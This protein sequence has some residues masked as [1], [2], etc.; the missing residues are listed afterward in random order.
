M[1]KEI[2]KQRLILTNDEISNLV[3]KVRSL[4]GKYSER[5]QLN[6]ALTLEEVL[7]DYQLAFGKDKAV[8]CVWKDDFFRGSRITISSPGQECNPLLM[9]NEED[10]EVIEYAQRMMN[11]LGMGTQYQYLRGCNVTTVKL[12]PKRKLTMLHQL[13]IAAAM[14]VLTMV[15][16]HFVP[17]N[18]AK[19][20]T[21]DFVTRIFQKMVSILA[22]LAT[23]LIFFALLTGIKNI[24]DVTSLGRMGKIVCAHLSKPYL[25]ALLLAP[26]ACIACY[27]LSLGGGSGESVFGSLLQLVLDII[28]DNLVTPLQVNNDLQV[29][30]IAVF[31]GTVLLMLKGEVS[32]LEKLVDES[33]KVVNRM[34]SLAC[35]GLPLLI[36]F[37]IISVS[38]QMDS[39]RIWDL[40]RF[41]LAMLAVQVIV[42]GF[43]VLRTCRLVRRPLKE[44][45]KPTVPALLI[46]L[47]TSSQM[48]SYPASEKCCK[49]GWGVEPKLFDFA[50][51]MGVVLYMPNGVVLLAITTWMMLY[52][53]GIPADFPMLVKVSFLSVIV[54][55][56]AP[57][58]PGS[59]LVVL[60]I[61]MTSTGVPLEFMPLGA[62]FVTVMGHIMPAMNG[63]CLQLEMLALG[64][65]LGMLK[66][67]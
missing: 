51:P 47:A 26:L 13:W 5:E 59:G 15:L 9:A 10:A 60:P 37:G 21:D 65:K 55:I 49:E 6:L 58:I 4:A 35:K 25:V 27:P 2:L 67:E 50:F 29:I 7:L 36:Y 24:G 18:M 64:K 53:A 43:V 42:I 46:N 14:A 12:P 39:G 22:T 30:V 40:Y 66:K 19:L 44:I 45:L 1:S 57:P 32:S 33:A 54:A 61:L 48:A 8:T 62:L 3:A 11:V 52:L 20:F 41:A 56:A 17:E 34:M 23:P 28:P 63:F 16:L 38:A 31:T